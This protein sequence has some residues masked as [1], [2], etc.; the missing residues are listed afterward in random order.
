MTRQ[1]E[2][3]AKK[4]LKKLLK[5]YH[6]QAKHNKIE[7]YFIYK[8][9]LYKIQIDEITEEIATFGRTSKKKG[10]KKVIRLRLL[11]AKKLEYLE[12]GKAVR[13]MTEK[14]LIELSQ[15]LGLNK[16]Q[17][18]EYLS[19][20]ARKQEY[21]LD[22]KRYDKGGDIELKRKSIQVKFQNATVAM[23]DTILKLQNAK[24]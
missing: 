20:R 7:I 13:V 22:S 19:A 24:V 11:N 5:D 2:R 12:S 21:K 9:V 14:H 17:T 18:C 10:N 1:E 8:K 6:N 3:T 4:E 16:G 15:K 23:V